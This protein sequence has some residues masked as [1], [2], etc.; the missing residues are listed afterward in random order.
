MQVGML[1]PIHHSHVPYALHILVTMQCIM[2][3]TFQQAAALAV[4]P[5]ILEN[6]EGQL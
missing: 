3:A 2:F 6:K 4:V 5:A 1:F